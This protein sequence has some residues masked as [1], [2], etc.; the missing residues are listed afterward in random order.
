MYVRENLTCPAGFE[1][2]SSAT[3]YCRVALE[4]ALVI[5]GLKSRVNK[6]KLLRVFDALKLVGGTCVRDQQ[7]IGWDITRPPMEHCF[8]PLSALMSE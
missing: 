7:I 2:Q 8:H 5:A 3:E 4:F 6:V 1:K